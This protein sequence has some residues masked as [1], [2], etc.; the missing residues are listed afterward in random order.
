VDNII[1]LKTTHIFLVPRA[2]AWPPASTATQAARTWDESIE[3]SLKPQLT[4]VN[5]SAFFGKKC[6]RRRHEWA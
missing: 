4:I 6:G 1:G 3:L 2:A 5:R